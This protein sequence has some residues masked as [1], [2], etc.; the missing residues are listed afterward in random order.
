M[1][2]VK[3]FRSSKLGVGKSKIAGRGIFARKKIMQGEIVAIKSGH[4]MD[5]NQYRKISKECKHF[6]LQIEDNFFLGPKINGEIKENGIF[7]NHSCDPNVGIRGQITYVAMRD[8]NKGEELTQDYAMGCT[9]MKTFSDLQ[10]C[11][12]GSKHC[13][14]VLKNSD[15][16]LKQL[17]KKYGNH[18]ADFIL[19]KIKK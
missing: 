14:K 1:S 19:R 15:W 11:S 7:I 2:T 10:K 6:C 18:F 3:S 8:I 12:C 4:I 17:Q 5:L 16:K 13:R 9:I